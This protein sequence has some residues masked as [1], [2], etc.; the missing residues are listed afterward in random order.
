MPKSASQKLLDEVAK[1]PNVT[2]ETATLVELF[3]DANNL[4]GE[5][6]QTQKQ[7]KNDILLARGQLEK[8]TDVFTGTKKLY[9]ANYASTLDLKSAELDVERYRVQKESADESLRLYKLYSLPKQTM[10]LLSAYREAGH[11]LRRTEAR[12]RSRM[13]QAPRPG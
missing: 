12:A 6:L 4:S 8:A 1:D 3:A 5:A 9:D 7:S 2:I 11:E 10:Q 13:A